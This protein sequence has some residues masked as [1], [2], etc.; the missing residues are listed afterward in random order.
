MQYISVKKMNRDIVV[1][2]DLE[3][4]ELDNLKPSEYENWLEFPVNVYTALKMES[5]RPEWQDRIGIVNLFMN[6]LSEEDQ[7]NLAK[8]LIYIN[9]TI[10]T[11]V[12]NIREDKNTI[13]EVNKELSGLIMKLNDDSNII[14]QLREFVKIHITPEISPSRGKRA[15]DKRATTFYPDEE[16]ELAALTIMCKL[17]FPVFGLYMH[18]LR[19]LVNV[20]SKDRHCGTIVIPLLDD[21]FRTIVRKLHGYAKKPIL[22]KSSNNPVY[23]IL[24][25][26]KEIL[27]SAVMDKVIVRNLVNAILVPGVPKLLNYVSSSNKNYAQ[28]STNTKV[29]KWRP[30]SPNYTSF[31][32]DEGNESNLEATILQS[33]KYPGSIGIMCRARTQSVGY[34]NIIKCGYDI[35]DYN[36]LT[37]FYEENPFQ[38]TSLA[39]SIL[40]KLYGKEFD[41]S[42]GIKYLR[43]RDISVLTK[44]VIL[45][46]L[47]KGYSNLIPILVPTRVVRDTDELRGEVELL[48]KKGYMQLDSYITCRDYYASC[49][50]DG[51]A[52]WDS[53]FEKVVIQYMDNAFVYNIPLELQNGDGDINGSE[54]LLSVEALDD[55]CKLIYDKIDED[56]TLYVRA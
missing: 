54:L 23:D 48:V 25:H 22:T 37:K 20:G 32:S 56:L 46:C 47:E 41:G 3:G 27:L 30:K 19:T 40:C 10:Y 45:E 4:L 43:Y 14:P 53:E 39:I 8:N 24:G 28:Y 42:R 44:L 33:S 7:K 16:L 21:N 38:I 11:H 2:L 31:D 34:N 1:R 5:T 6:S 12:E 36:N 17:L 55:M 15:Q 50:K 49:V 26:N 52:R 9:A 13:F 51:G 29:E 18:V 35:N